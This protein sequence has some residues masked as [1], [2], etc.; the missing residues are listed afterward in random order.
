MAAPCSQWIACSPVRNGTSAGR[1]TGSLGSTVE[2]AGRFTLRQRAWLFYGIAAGSLFAVVI[3]GAITLGDRS[4]LLVV[5]ALTWFGVV[6]VLQFVYL[7]CPH[8]GHVAIIT[9]R[10]VATPFVGEKCR[11]CGKEY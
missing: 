10:G 1:S 7:K 9:P 8:C 6:G 5:A 4:S 3:L 11:Y 2:P